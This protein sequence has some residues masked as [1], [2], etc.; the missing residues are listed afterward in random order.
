MSKEIF[1]KAQ[2]LQERILKLTD[3]IYTLWFNP[4]AT[5]KHNIK[6]I[7][8]CNNDDYCIDLNIHSPSTAQALDIVKQGFDEELNQAKKEFIN[9]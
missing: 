8:I 7:T 1:E 2:R 4:K 3:I 9:L 6:T 5:H